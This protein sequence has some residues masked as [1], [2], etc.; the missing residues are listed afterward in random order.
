MDWR[1]FDNPT[2]LVSYYSG[3]CCVFLHKLQRKVT[4]AQVDTRTVYKKKYPSTGIPC[5]AVRVFGL[6][7]LF[8]KVRSTT[9][10]IIK[11]YNPYT[12]ILNFVL[13]I[14]EERNSGCYDYA[15]ACRE[16]A[17]A[18]RAKQIH[19]PSTAILNKFSTAV[20][21]CT[22]RI[23]CRIVT[24]PRFFDSDQKRIQKQYRYRI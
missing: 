21:S 8:W 23:Q 9:L 1:V 16:R 22:R 11:T 10:R 17:R 4:T 5:T 15:R 7:T 20:V 13:L 6:K 12:K 14:W 24:L 2:A 19:Q 3:G 18:A